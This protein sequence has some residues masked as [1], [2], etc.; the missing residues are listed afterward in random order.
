MKIRLLGT[1]LLFLAT[2]ACS[3]APSNDLSES[4]GFS[5][6]S[7]HKG[8]SEGQEKDIEESEEQLVADTGKASDDDEGIPGYLLDPDQINNSQDFNG[9][10][11]I[12]A[13]PNTVKVT[14]DKP[15][16]I[17]AW[18]LEREMVDSANGILVDG[19][20]DAATIVTSKL[21]KADGSF[22]IEL[23][24]VSREQALVFSFSY[25]EQPMSL[26][27]VVAERNTYAGFS[28]N[29]ASSE[30]N[31]QAGNPGM[32]GFNTAG[33]DGLVSSDLMMLAAFDIDPDMNVLEQ[34]FD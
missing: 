26:N 18:Q 1:L 2:V 30:A 27:F 15:V 13:R 24:N 3:K 5:G 17:I 4:F 21:V 22:N 14:S 9:N 19:G 28:Y 10:R 32:P 31:A 23:N 11:T 8:S 16:Y 7:L 25:E 6:D 34:M 33:I 12:S 29:A 20:A